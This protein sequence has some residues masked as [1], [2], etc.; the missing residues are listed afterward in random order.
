MTPRTTR[1]DARHVWKTFGLTYADLTLGRVQKLRK[2]L[3]DFMKA[4]KGMPG[5]RMM[6]APKVSLHQGGFHIEMFCKAAHF[7]KR[8]AV[9]FNHEGFIGFAGWADDTNAE[10]VAIAFIAWCRWMRAEVGR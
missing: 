5:W 9:T 4:H 6:G 7:T 3:D 10:V 2:L 1:N 8:E